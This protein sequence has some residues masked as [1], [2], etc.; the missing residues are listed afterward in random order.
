MEFDVYCDETRIAFDASRTSDVSGPRK[1][2]DRWSR[3]SGPS[4]CRFQ[5]VS[6]EQ[7]NGS[8]LPKEIKTVDVA[9]CEGLAVQFLSRTVEELVQSSERRPSESSGLRDKKA[10][11]Q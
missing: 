7:L 9:P 8:S 1:D 4:H 2:N 5:A 11:A 10:R 6:R 3:P